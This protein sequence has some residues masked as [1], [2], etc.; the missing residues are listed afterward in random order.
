MT[1]LIGVL[2]L[3]LCAALA[4][5]ISMPMQQRQMRSRAAISPEQ[6]RN[7]ALFRHQPASAQFKVRMARNE[8]VRRQAKARKYYTVNPNKPSGI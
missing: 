1:L 7:A 8:Q 5:F 4:L 3:M 6:Q 2:L